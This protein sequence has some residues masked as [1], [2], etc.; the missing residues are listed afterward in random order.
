MCGIAGFFN[1]SLPEGV[2]KKN[3]S[4]MLQA[5]AH[6][7]PDGQGTWSDASQG[8]HLGMRRLSIIDLSGGQQPI[9]NE[10]MTLAVFFNGEIYNYLELR[11][12][13][14]AAGHRFRTQSDTEVLVHL[15]ERDGEAMLDSL[16][17][18]FAIALYDLR[19]RRLLLARDPSGQKPLFYY[20]DAHRFAFGSEIKALLALPFVP[21][22]ANPDAFW[23][24]I[25]WHCLPAPETHFRHIHKLP[26][27]SSLWLNL[28]NPMAGEVKAFAEIR[29][30]IPLTDLDS[31]V[32]ALDAALRE[33]TEI[34]LRADVPVGVLLSSGIDS[35]TVASYVHDQRPGQL[36][37]FTAVFHEG[38]SEQH[39]AET[40]AKLIGS[41]HHNIPLS[42]QDLADNLPA[43]AWFLDEPIA[44]PAAFAIYKVC[45]YARQ[46]VK[47]LLGGEGSDELFAGY[48]G[49][50]HGMLATLER[51]RKL[52]QWMGWL[53]AKNGLE[54][55]SAFFRALHRTHLSPAQETILLRV[56]GF[57][58]DVRSPLL[59]SPEQLQRLDKRAL[60][61]AATTY[62]EYTS[63]LETL[64][65]LDR[66][67]QLPESLLV[68]AD[69]MS[70]AAS[71]ELRAPFLDSEIEKLA[72]RMDM[73][74]KLPPG[75]AGKWVLFKCL[76]RRF[77]DLLRREKKGFPIPL[78]PWLRGPL[79]PQLEAALFD[80]T[81]VL[82][83]LLDPVRLR[84]AWKAFL[85][86]LCPP[87]P[88]YALWMYA[89]WH[90]EF[91][92][93][94]ETIRTDA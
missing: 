82:P 44:D 71:I 19:N 58:G 14:E 42:A 62:K 26:P 12:E 45:Q 61:Y 86:G 43:I 65:H 92:R 55:N 64:L 8:L 88:F 53:P 84:V 76:E 9:W 16:R 2:A 21:D 34:H 60:H 48:T 22:E 6:R 87:S 37:T 63:P 4:R 91:R 28:A 39:G 70:M 47:V 17:G 72:D 59:L 1:S 50:Y 36:S 31:A 32:T 74:L 93:K 75:G 30:D 11:R 18:M 25:S 52:R 27:R 51:S 24:Y 78:A 40:T 33:S 46:H 29:K 83:G 35:Q 13:L 38:D 57:P 15:F 67:W 3:L 5:I 80:T 73:G 79:R 54:N 69:R 10:D 20:R 56:E 49:R 77:P 90:Q 85:D 41:S 89:A 7:G 68:K 94:L 66:R 23:D 81:S